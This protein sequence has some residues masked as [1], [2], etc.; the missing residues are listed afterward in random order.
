MRF[1][2]TTQSTCSVQCLVKWQIPLLM[3]LGASAAFSQPSP[4]GDLSN[5]QYRSVFSQYKAFNE[6]EVAPWRQTND[7]VEKAGGWRVYAKEARK[8]D[9]TE[10]KA[11][12]DAEKSKPHDMQGSKK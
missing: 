6:Q 4:A 3:S 9:A 7:A 10:E 5:L 2:N 12:P 8:P 1:F 11:K